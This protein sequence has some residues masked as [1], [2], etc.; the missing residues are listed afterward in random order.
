MFNQYFQ[1]NDII[2]IYPQLLLALFAL[3]VL[4]VDLFL[5]REWKVLNAFTALV[6]VGYAAYALF[7][8]RNFNV[9]AYNGAIV[10]DSFAVFFQFV[11]LIATALVILISAR[12]LSIEGEHRG[13]YYALILF[14]VLGMNFMVMGMDLIT[15]YIALEL[16]A[17]S[18]YVLVGYL[19]SNRQSNEAAMK[20]FLLGAFSSGILLYGISLLYGLSG[21]TDLRV[22]AA[23]LAERPA[24]DPLSMIAL[25]TLAA[26]LLFK[27]AGVPFHQWLPDAYE[28][29]PSSITTFIS[30]APKFASFALILRLL[31]VALKP[32]QVEWT[33][34]LIVVCVLTMTLGNITAISQSNIKRLLAYSSIAHAGYLMLGIIAANEYGITG[35]AIYFLT[36]TFMNIGAW[37]VVVAMRRKNMIG[38]QI[39]EMS[40]MIHKNPAAAVLMLIFLL[41]LAGIPPTAGFIGK[42]YL[43]AAVIQ[44][45]HYILAV[46]AVLNAAVSLYY[47]MRVV[48]MMFMTDKTDEEKIT[49]SPG[50]ITALAVTTIF[51]ILIGVYPQ[52]FIHFAQSSLSLFQ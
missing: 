2:A 20:F 15:L 21:S 7:R 51:T 30:V 50:L 46:I 28:G 22:I 3:G 38:D 52:P 45:K 44:T 41:S 47:Y 14:S 5:D 25:I 48:V 42:Y 36:Y 37:T 31:F 34:L 32:L 9:T 16:M 6:G 1:P 18:E 26:G 40:G 27:V 12:Y 4:I 19:R 17:V 10:N 11:F 43:F 49:L 8:I 35:I 29:A 13:D 23:K 24:H 39:S 33:P